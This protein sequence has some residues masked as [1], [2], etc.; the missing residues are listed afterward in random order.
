MEV[1]D[2]FLAGFMSAGADLAAAAVAEMTG[3]ADGESGS[4]G[5]DLDYLA[6]L[7]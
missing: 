5:D 2:D 4:E 3:E 7:S 6:L 1:D